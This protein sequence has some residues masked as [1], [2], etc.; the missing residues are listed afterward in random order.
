[1]KKVFLLTGILSMLFAASAFALA[2]QKIIPSGVTGFNLS[3]NVFMGYTS[4]TT[5]GTGFAYYTIG[6]KHSSGSKKFGAISTDTGMYAK[7]STIAAFTDTEVPT[8]PTGSGTSVSG[9]T[10]M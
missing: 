2:F 10:S 3:K 1:M 5:L 4:G 9:W 8:L 7:D 6:T